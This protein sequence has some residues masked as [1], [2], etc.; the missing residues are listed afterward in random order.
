MQKNIFSHHKTEILYDP[1][2]YL[3][4][5]RIN[6]KKKVNNTDRNKL[7]AI[8]RLTNQKNFKFFW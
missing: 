8:G 5:I 1:V 2:L 4:K 7:I 6:K 3:K